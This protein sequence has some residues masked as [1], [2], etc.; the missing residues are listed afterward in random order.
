L[1]WLIRLGF[2]FHKLTNPLVRAVLS[3]SLHPML[4]GRLILITYTAKKSRVSHTLPVQYTKSDD[5]LIVVAGYHRYK[6][7]WRN[8]RRESVV[9][10]SYHGN[11]VKAHARAFEGDTAAI[12]PRL[13]AYLKRF[14][15]SARIRG[16]TFDASGDV[17]N[18]QKLAEEASRVVMVIIRI[19]T[20][21]Q[22]RND[23]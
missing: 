23:A 18:K 13:P 15:E 21:S 12:A 1:N 20:S 7:W 6:K 5:E 4:G 16:L 2:L 14:P 17:P 10:I 8:L 22:V 3:S 9:N 19:P 11:W